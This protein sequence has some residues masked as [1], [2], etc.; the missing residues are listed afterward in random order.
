M[1]CVWTC[2]A[3]NEVVRISGHL[4]STTAGAVSAGFFS[5][6]AFQKK[7]MTAAAPNS[8]IAETP[9][10]ATSHGLFF[11]L[12]VILRDTIDTASRVKCPYDWKILV[13]VGSRQGPPRGGT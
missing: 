12:T 7:P 5:V 8:A 6:R 11:R 9:I 2:T 3:C 4:A 1:A 13:G 10:E